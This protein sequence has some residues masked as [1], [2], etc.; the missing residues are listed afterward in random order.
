MRRLAVRYRLRF[1]TAQ[2]ETLLL[3]SFCASG[4][5]PE[6]NDRY[7]PAHS[8]DTQTILHTDSKGWPSRCPFPNG[9]D[10]RLLRQLP[11]PPPQGRGQR[12]HLILI[13]L[14]LFQHP[15]TCSLSPS[16]NPFLPEVHC[17][18]EYTAELVNQGLRHTG[19]GFMQ[20][21]V[22][23][24]QA[25]RHRSTARETGHPSKNAH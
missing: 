15:L 6:I 4:K 18:Y 8:A 19:I 1:T 2:F 25:F 14:L 12:Q 21:R 3:T 13:Y 10:R 24:L 17:E 20:R 16:Q 9:A 22:V 7:A 23:L 11:R 5:Q